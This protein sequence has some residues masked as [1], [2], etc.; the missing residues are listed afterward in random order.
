MGLNWA[1]LVRKAP[2]RDHELAAKLGLPDS[3]HGAAY[4]PAHDD[5]MR[6]LSYRWTPE[7]RLLL[8]CFAGCTWEDITR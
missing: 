2:L 8:N 6:S 4:C 5:R 7:D 3:G 1:Q